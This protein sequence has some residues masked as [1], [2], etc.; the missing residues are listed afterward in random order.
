MKVLSFPII[1][2][3]DVG[4]KVIHDSRPAPLS[5]QLHGV[6]LMIYYP[7]ALV[8]SKV[9]GRKTVFNKQINIYHLSRK[10]SM[11]DVKLSS[12]YRLLD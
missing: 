9:A 3:P 6:Y 5:W 8:Y 10:R 7:S 2:W 4:V 1:D 11:Q 12:L